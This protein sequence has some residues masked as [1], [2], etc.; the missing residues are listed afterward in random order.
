MSI[1]TLVDSSDAEPFPIQ[2]PIPK[3]EAEQEMKDMVKAL[4]GSAARNEVTVEDDYIE[5][6]GMRLQRKP[7]DRHTN[8]CLSPP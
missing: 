1:G 2:P 5:V 3:W 4:G 8:A 7:D 6:E